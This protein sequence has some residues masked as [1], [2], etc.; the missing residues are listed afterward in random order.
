MGKIRP[1]YIATT[2][3]IDDDQIVTP[4]ELATKQDVLVSGSNIKTVGGASILGSGNVAVGTGTVTSVSVTTTN[5][6]SGTVATATSTPAIS[7]TLGAITP[8]SINSVGTL[9]GSNLSG[10]NTG[11]NA[12][13]S[14][15][16]GLAASKQDTLVSATNIKT[17]NGSTLLGSGDLVVTAVIPLTQIEPTTSQTIT[18]GYSAYVVGPY[19]IAAITSLE[20][21]VGACLEIG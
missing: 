18:A 2:T 5:G 9:I 19:E 20:I 7:L 13:N 10:T 14:Q 4:E 16:S 8:A 17:V 6:V 12:T 1:K 15:Y 21:G 11:D 3:L